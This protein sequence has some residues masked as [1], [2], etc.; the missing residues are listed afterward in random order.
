[1]AV[2][3]AFAAAVLAVVGAWELL[4]AVERTRVAAALE[5]AIAPLVRAGTE[6]ASPTS[7]ER[8]R[9][10]VL[11]AGTLAAAGWLL[12]GVPVALIAGVS[13]PAL[14]TALVT[15]RR[16]RFRAALQQ[17]APAVARAL[18]DALS[19]GHSIRGALATLTVPGP[20][21]HELAG[22]ARALA[23][24]A[25]TQ[26]VLER[27]RRKANAPAWDAIVAGV[28]LQRDAGGDLPNL[29][30]DLAGALETAQR[31]ERDAIAATAQARFTARIVL[32][33]P[34]GAV[35]LAELA[36]PGLLQSLL[37]NPVSVA[38]TTAALAF[39]LVALLTMARISRNVAR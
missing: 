34:L 3:L 2:G 5:R 17:S 22:A 32:V 6:G 29:L 21:G 27:L 11:A 7:T 1:M 8:R 30:R 35:V 9:L 14:A 39:Q 33:L 15:A 38:L 16:R 20:G 28:L 36:K 26:T 4:A 24:G 25:D 13:G 37:T 23:L 19:A 31:Q 12:G 10:A 18:A